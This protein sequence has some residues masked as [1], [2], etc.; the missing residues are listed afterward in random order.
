MTSF[1]LVSV[2]TAA[3]NMG[4]YLPEAIE[5]VLKQDY[6]NI[7]LIVVN[8][9]STDDTCEI[10]GKY[11]NDPRVKIIHQENKGQTAAKNRGFAEAK[12]ELIAFCDADNRWLPG[13]LKLQVPLLMNN[14]GVGV[15]YGDIILIDGSGNRK[16]PTRTKRYSGKITARLLRDNFVTFNTTLISRELM[17][18]MNGFDESLRMAIDYDLWLRISLD[19]EF[20]FVP[21]P[22]VEYR[23][24]EGQMSHRTGERMDNFFQLLNK[25]IC[26]NPGRIAP[27]EARLAWA[28]SYT[29]KAN[30]LSSIG[31]RR[32]AWH[33]YF[34]AL[35]QRPYD[36]RLLKSMI[37][38]GLNRY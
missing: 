14:P 7:E 32:E 9:G 24:W 11:G 19:H 30:W 29:T 31:R 33:L 13:K 18:E 20:L 37:K 16:P 27:A 38:A 17:Q 34:R 28:H 22:L 21:E 15:V 4:H 23:I 12:G 5:S 8:D 3:F 2:I 25:F 35:R 26:E 1:P 6:P 36:S 10:L